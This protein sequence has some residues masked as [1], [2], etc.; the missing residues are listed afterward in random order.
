MT[1]LR[2]WRGAEMRSLRWE[3][4]RDFVRPKKR[5]STKA[6]RD[7]SSRGKNGAHSARRAPRNDSSKVSAGSRSEKSAMGERPL[8]PFAQN[9]PFA[10]QDKKDGAPEKAKAGTT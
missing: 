7:S 10:S 8:P 5:A 9:A 2:F 1:A 6:R 4:R 3:K